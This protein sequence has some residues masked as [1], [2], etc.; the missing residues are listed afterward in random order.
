MEM[1]VEIFKILQS[2]PLSIRCQRVTYFLGIRIPEVYGL[3]GIP[4]RESK[5]MRRKRVFSVLDCG[6]CSGIGIG[7]SHGNRFPGQWLV[8]DFDR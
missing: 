5:S 3:K 2:G 6:H 1:G 7:F 4:Q 8:F